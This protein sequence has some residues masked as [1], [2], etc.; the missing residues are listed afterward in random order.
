MAFKRF[1]LQTSYYRFMIKF[2][3]DYHSKISSN[4]TKNEKNNKS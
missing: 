3:F 1:G 2:F 4:K